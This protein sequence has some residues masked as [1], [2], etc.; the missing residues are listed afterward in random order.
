MVNIHLGLFL[1]AVGICNGQEPTPVLRSAAVDTGDK[2]A[3]G[4]TE[5]LSLEHGSNLPYLLERQGRRHLAVG[6]MQAQSCNDRYS[7]CVDWSAF[8]G[9]QSVHTGRITIPCGR[10]VVMDY[11]GDTLTLQGGLDIQ[12]K[13]E[14]PNGY[15]GLT[16][17]ST[18]IVVQGEL[19]MASTGKVTGSPAVKFEMIG[20]RDELFEPIGEN[21]GY[22]GG[23]TCLAGKKAITVA[24][25]RVDIQGLP[26]DTKT[27]VK[28]YDV[29]GSGNMVNGIVVPGAG[30][31]G[32]WGVGAEVLITSHTQSGDDQQVRK[33][34]SYDTD[35]SRNGYYRMFLDRPILSP[36]TTRDDSDFAVEVALLSRNIVFEGGDDDVAFHG[37][38]FWI[39]ETSAYEQR[40][41][42]VEVINFG[43]VRTLAKNA[44]FP[45]RVFL[46]VDS[47]FVVLVAVWRSL[48]L[49]RHG[50][51]DFLS[52]WGAGSLPSPRASLR[53]SDWKRLFQEHHSTIPPALRG[54]S[55][56]GQYDH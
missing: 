48:S 24:G 37:G 10:C 51:L 15:S 2:E 30:V 23:P 13:L 4:S 33:I 31:V 17:R 5:R 21:K 50:M 25:G 14:F 56:H 9:T 20:N 28:L 22:C 53:R 12:G 44:R 52:G 36:T 1:L 18:T 16:L 34:V 49:T 32:S 7:A 54:R 43:Q 26:A 19:E 45:A 40:V 29:I 39:F 41:D 3:I 27:W 42:G 46:R 35:Y 47:D 38:H 8:V 11:N 55:C 6:G